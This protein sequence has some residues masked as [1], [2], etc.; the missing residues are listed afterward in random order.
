[1]PV[2]LTMTTKWSAEKRK[3]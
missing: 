1:M 3:P 2:T